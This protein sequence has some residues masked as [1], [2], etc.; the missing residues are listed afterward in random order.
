MPVDIWPFAT[1]G[2]HMMAAG[3]PAIGFGPGNLTLA[4]TNREHILI[5]DMLEAVVSC[6]F[7]SRRNSPREVILTC[8]DKRGT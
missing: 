4:H 8:D 5:N 2:G 7:K 3:I 6:I 1:D